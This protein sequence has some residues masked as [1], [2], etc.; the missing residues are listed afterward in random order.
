V[1]HGYIKLV[2]RKASKLNVK[3]HHLT[4]HGADRKSR[5]R[6]Y[7]EIQELHNVV[8]V[9]RI[10]D[11]LSTAANKSYRFESQADISGCIK[12][13]DH[14]KV[15]NGKNINYAGTVF[16]YFE[17]SIARKYTHRLHRTISYDLKELESTGHYVAFIKNDLY[18]DEFCQIFHDC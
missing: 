17:N 5:G 12:P 3:F 15:L 9:L 1:T 7:A 13:F 2:Y 4:N 10:V 8:Q 6:F 18:E 11:V 14:K 16:S